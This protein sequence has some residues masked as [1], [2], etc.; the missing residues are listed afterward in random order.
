MTAVRLNAAGSDE[1]QSAS[2]VFLDQ[3]LVVFD[4][5]QAKNATQV[6]HISR[7]PKTG[8]V[9]FRFQTNAP[10]RYIVSPNCGIIEN[11][12]PVPIR[13]ELVG[14]RYNPQ[15]KLVVHAIA[16]Q[17]KSEWKSIWDDP[18]ID[19]PGRF[20]TIWIELGTTIMSLEHAF[21]LTD[22]QNAKV[23]MSVA[24]LLSASNSRGADRVK[25]LEDLKAMLRADNE[26]L[27]R[28]IQQTTNLKAVIEKQLKERS[29]EAKEFHAKEEKL[30]AE[31][32]R[33]YADVMRDESELNILKERRSHPENCILM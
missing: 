21:N 3:T 1:P 31:E 23:T 4:I 2:V 5:E 24:Q 12:K 26:T 8:L 14:N 10:T 13:I 9:S 15:H 6:I 17:N 33:L 11:D 18:R 30:T 22:P 16:I 19:E 20:Q 7:V 28:N 32:D 29:A 25:E 27:Q